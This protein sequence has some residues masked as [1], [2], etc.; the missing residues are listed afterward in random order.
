MK[1]VAGQTAEEFLTQIGTRMMPEKGLPIGIRD[2]GGGT[3]DIITIQRFGS[4]AEVDGL[5][6]F[7]YTEDGSPLPVGI[8]DITADLVATASAA[9]A[10]G[11]MEDFPQPDQQPAA[12]EPQQLYDPAFAFTPINARTVDSQDPFLSFLSS[13]L[14]TFSYYYTQIVNS[15]H[16]MDCTLR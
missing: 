2:I 6:R 1:A 13:C 7:E 4:R 10:L 14:I 16:C 8:E 15:K 9:T 12:S 3:C 11:S 5:T